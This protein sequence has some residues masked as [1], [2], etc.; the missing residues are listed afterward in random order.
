MIILFPNGAAIDSSVIASIHVSR[1]EQI[2]DGLCR[3]ANIVVY[4]FRGEGLGLSLFGNQRPTAQHFLNI[5]MP[6]DLTAENECRR[7]VAKW[8][9]LP[10]PT[11]MP[12]PTARTSGANH[13]T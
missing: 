1:S 7:L 8:A 12:D 6:D 13:D 2:R 9:G 4:T 5:Q 10:E 3:P 11:P